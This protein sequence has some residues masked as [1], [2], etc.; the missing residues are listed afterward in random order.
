[1]S[2]YLRAAAF[3]AAVGSTASGWALDADSG[4]AVQRRPVVLRHEP[5]VPLTTR[6]PGTGEDVR[7]VSS[8][9]FDTVQL[10]PVPP[11]EELEGC[12]SVSEVAVAATVTE[13]LGVLTTDQSWI[14]TRLVA[15]VDAVAVASTR[16]LVQR[17]GTIILYHDGGTMVIGRDRVTS[18]G[19][20]VFSIG[21]R[22][23]LF[24]VDNEAGELEPYCQWH[25]RADDRMGPVKDNETAPPELGGFTLAEIIAA[26]AKP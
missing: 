21:S 20:P 26:L 16:R 10:D 24:L 13:S 18:G 7:L 17:G 4:R 11:L 25:A 8:A 9:T 22:Y 6:L 2:K 23:V 3:V 12:A 5:G 19:G 14:R 15:R 1:M